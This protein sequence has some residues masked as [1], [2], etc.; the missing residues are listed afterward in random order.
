[1]VIGRWLIRSKTI[2]TSWAM[3]RLA[4]AQARSRSGRGSV[5]VVCRHEE[6]EGFDVFIVERSG[7]CDG[8]LDRVAGVCGEPFEHRR[9]RS[10][11]VSPNPSIRSMASWIA[12]PLARPSSSALSAAGGRE[13]QVLGSDT[14][15]A[16]HA[17][18][19]VDEQDQ[20]VGVV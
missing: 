14:R 18:F 20:V 5:G 13:Q 19:V 8:R 3:M 9:G 6:M 10:T 16:E 17:D 1:M 7:G 12:G 11:S 4:S 2:S 15:V